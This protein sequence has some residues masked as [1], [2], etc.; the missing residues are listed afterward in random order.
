MCTRKSTHMSRIVAALIRVKIAL[1]VLSILALPTV[2]RAEADNT[3][4]RPISDFVST[5][6]TYCTDDGQGG[7][8]IFVPPVANF[9]G[10]D[11]IDGNPATPDFCAAIDYAGLADAYILSQNPALTLKTRTSGIITEHR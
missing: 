1:L 3:S 2:A 5:Q 4:V 11:N 10:W 6:G 7:C 8:V 9:I